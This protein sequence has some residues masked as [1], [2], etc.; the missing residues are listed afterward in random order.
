MRGHIYGSFWLGF[1]V[2][3]ALGVAVGYGIELMPGIG[4]IHL[5]SLTMGEPEL[6]Q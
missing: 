5:P 3:F 2:G 4:S 6:R 1:G